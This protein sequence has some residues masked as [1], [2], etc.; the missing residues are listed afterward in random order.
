MFIFSTPVIV[1]EKLDEKGKTRHGKF[2]GRRRVHQATQTTNQDGF[3]VVSVYLYRYV[4]TCLWP[5]GAVVVDGIYNVNVRA[6]Q[7]Q[8]SSAPPGVVINCFSKAASI[9]G[10]PSSNIRSR[11]SSSDSICGFLSIC[12]PL[13]RLLKSMS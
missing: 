1:F 6:L 8:W 3:C 5:I 4:R 13:P 10:K 12:L 11:F 2:R 7:G 9:A